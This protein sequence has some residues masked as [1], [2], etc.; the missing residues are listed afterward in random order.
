MDQSAVWHELERG[1]AVHLYTGGPNLSH[2][3]IDDFSEDRRLVWVRLD[4]LNERK[5]VLYEDG[6]GIVPIMGKFSQRR[7]NSL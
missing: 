6:V 5:L 3:T 7:A 4:E 1:D 2:A